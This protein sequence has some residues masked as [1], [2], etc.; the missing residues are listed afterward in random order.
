MADDSKKIKTNPADWADVLADTLPVLKSTY[1]PVLGETYQFYNVP[2]FAGLV[3]WKHGNVAGDTLVNLPVQGLVTDGAQTIPGA[4]TFST[5]PKGPSSDPTADNELTRKA[6][7][8]GLLGTSEYLDTTAGDIAATFPGSP[9]AGQI[10]RVYNVGTGGFHATTGINSINIGDGKGLTFEYTGSVWRYQDAS[11]E[12]TQLTSEMLVIKW[13][14][15]RQLLIDEWTSNN[16]ARDIS[17]ANFTSVKQ[18]QIST[19]NTSSSVAVANIDL[20]S[21]TSYTP[22]AFSS[23]S[24]AAATPVLIVTIEGRWKAGV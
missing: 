14:G 9:S 3:V 10:H 11:I 4:K 20:Y 22:K 8:L 15:G 1:V 2:G 16:S 6:Y 5:I 17:A 21:T 23:A 19:D 18:P 12:E 13:A 24:G 7:V